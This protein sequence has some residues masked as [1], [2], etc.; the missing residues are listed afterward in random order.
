MPATQKMINLK[1]D[2]EPLRVP[3]GT[4]LIHAA[5]KLGIH[6]PRLCYHPALSIEGACRV[7]VVQVKGFNYFLTAC[8]Q[9]VWEGMEVDT[10]SPVIRQARRDI[11]EL[12]LDN[13]PKDCQTCDRDGNCE[14][15]RQAYRLGVRDR[16]FDH[17]R[18]AHAEAGLAVDPAA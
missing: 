14:L 3:A 7:C 6:I 1:I 18:R 17:V 12:L 5:E 2:D 8:S 11:L 10:N 15:Q 4:K 13:H 9:Q 16:L